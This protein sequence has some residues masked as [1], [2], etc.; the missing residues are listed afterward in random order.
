MKV[1]LS[2]TLCWQGYWHHSGDEIDLPD[3]LASKYI[4]AGSAE[5]LTQP[6]ET[7]AIIT[8]PPKGKRDV[9]NATAGR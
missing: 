8:T 1:R 3:E 5:P 9:R 4:A 6:I 7:A 2:T